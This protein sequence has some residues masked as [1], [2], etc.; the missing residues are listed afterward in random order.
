LA[1]YSNGGWVFVAP[2]IGW[3]AWIVDAAEAAIFDGTGW[4]NGALAMSPNGAALHAETVEIEVALG[5]GGAAETDPIIPTA[6]VVIGVSGI[7]SQAITGT[8]SSW[9]LGVATGPDRY[10]SGLGVS[11][12]SWV[13]GVTG[14]PQAYYTPTSLRLEAEGGEF[15]GGKVR[16]AVHLLR[17][18][19]PRV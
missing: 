15:S 16:L 13:Q 1:V 5:T 7:V 14:Q 17:I 3:R 4:V 9:R 10:G 6:A 2:R 12:G 18:G 8:L 11:L 19:I